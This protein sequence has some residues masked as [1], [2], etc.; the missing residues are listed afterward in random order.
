MYNIPLSNIYNAD[1]TNCYY[2]LESKYTLTKR[3]SRTVAVRGS[4]STSRCTLMLGVSMDGRKL[5]PYIVFKGEKKGRIAGEFN[6]SQVHGY[7][8]GVLLCTQ[9]HAWFDE[10][11]MLDWIE[12][13]WG[14]KRGEKRK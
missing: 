11:V 7:P 2:S 1:Q 3:G 14:K 12:K 6:N 13:C 8:E 10:D 9:N 4:G 5:P